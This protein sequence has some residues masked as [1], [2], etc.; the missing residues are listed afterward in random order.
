MSSA[1]IRGTAFLFVAALILAA[2]TA[3]PKPE[4]PET[5]SPVDVTGPNQLTA[6]EMDA[7]R[8]QVRRCWSPPVGVPDRDQVIVTL[9]LALNFD[10]SLRQME[11][12]EKEKLNRE[13]FYEVS[14]QAAMRAVRRCSPLTL[15]PDKYESWKTL[16]LTFNPSFLLDRR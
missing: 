11:V 3:R 2:C 1:L 5:P 9:R 8:T 10:G 7:V 12:T 6:E 4:A 13:R 16:Y 14:A 15:P